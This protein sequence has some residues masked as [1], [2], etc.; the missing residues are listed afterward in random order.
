MTADAQPRE[1]ETETCGRCGGSGRNSY[2]QTWGD[3]CFG[4]GKP[5]VPGS[6]HRLTKRG[7]EAMRFFTASMSK[8]VSGVVVGDRVRLPSIGG[9][10]WTTVTEI[11]TP[12]CYSTAET[13][14]RHVEL[15]STNG[16]W[17]MLREGVV[18][19]AQTDDE[20]RAKREAALDYQDTLTKAGTVRKSSKKTETAT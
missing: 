2:T 14:E 19:V 8:P 1:F 20:K 11:C 7:A 3:A 17:T 15:R 18:R 13:N 4:C 5:H 6:G 12:S 16:S 9:G 10:Q